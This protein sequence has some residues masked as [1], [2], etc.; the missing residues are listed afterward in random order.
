[1]RNPSVF[2]IVLVALTGTAS[3]EPERIRYG[4]SKPP[5]PP[6]AQADETWT[7]L[8][9]PTPAA[10]GTEF[11]DVGKEAGTFAKIRI[12]A[13]RATIVVRGVKIY[14]D[15]GT[16]K[17][18]QVDTALAP[19]RSTDIDFKTPRAIDHVVITTEQHGK[20]EYDLYGSSPTGVAAR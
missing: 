3:A 2:A 19:K 14:F 8:T 10:H 4:D 5:D 15:D 20:G 12:E 16:T 9:T 18:V 7:K 13:H 1:M 6:P 17:F 11:I